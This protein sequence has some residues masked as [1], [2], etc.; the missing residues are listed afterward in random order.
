MDT[1]RAS[2]SC[3]VRTQLGI[4]PVCDPAHV[5]TGG[6]RSCAEGDWAELGLRFGGTW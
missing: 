4:P 2:L 3:M 6:G 1:P 5:F